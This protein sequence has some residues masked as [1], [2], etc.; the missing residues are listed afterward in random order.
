MVISD[1]SAKLIS[2]GIALSSVIDLNELLELILFKA[3]ELTNADAGTI[4]SVDGNHLVFL[5]SQNDT[6]EK[7]FGKE[8]VKNLFEHFSLPMNKKSVAGYV[9]LTGKSLIIDDLYKNEEYDFCSYREWDRANGYYSKSML[10]LPLKTPRNEV[11]GV[12]QLINA[13]QGEQIIPFKKE[14][15]EPMRYFAAQAAVALV[16]AKLYQEIEEAHLDTLFRLGVAAEYRDKETASHIRRVGKMA[17]LL[18]KELGWMDETELYWAVAMHDVGKLGIPDVILQKPGPLTS[19]ERKIMEKHTLIGG[20]ILRNA[21][22]SL[23][24]QA[25]VVALT[26]HERYD[27]RGYPRGLKGEDIPLIGRIAAIVDVF[28]ALSSKRVYKPPFSEREVEMIL[29]EEKGH[30]FDPL[31]VEILLDKW[32][33]FWEIKKIEREEQE[34]ELFLKD[35]SWEEIWQEIEVKNLYFLDRSKIGN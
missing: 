27:G 20:Y 12:L 29:L 19:E 34:K 16:N 32:N 4:Y 26:H 25:Q 31:L 28:D 2:V 22:S 6:L 1:L 23:L 18:G 35:V 30:H 8:K 14:F 33:S 21:K 10:V 11:V 9:A 15:L 7:R 24:K 5:T 3:R 17:V 13:K